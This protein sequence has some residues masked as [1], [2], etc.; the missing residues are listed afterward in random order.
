MIARVYHISHFQGESLQGESAQKD[1]SEICVS[2]MLFCNQIFVNFNNQF[3]ENSGCIMEGHH[4]ALLLSF[5]LQHVVKWEKIQSGKI[6]L[7]ET[8]LEM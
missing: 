7:V 5:L 4:T 2:F 6:Q 8:S 1:L 3:F